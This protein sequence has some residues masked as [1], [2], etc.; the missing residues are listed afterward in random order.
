MSLI[1]TNIKN[2]L[3]VVMV[4]NYRISIRR[5][6]SI[7]VKLNHKIPVLFNNLKN[8]DSHLIM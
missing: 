3:L 4:I 1:Q 7:N 6:C 8:F 5:V 2:M